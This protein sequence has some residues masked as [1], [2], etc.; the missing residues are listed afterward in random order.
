[1][2]AGISLYL[3]VQKN[4]GTIAQ[5]LWHT[6]ILDTYSIW[7]F[8]LLQNGNII[9]SYMEYFLYF[10]LCQS[11]S[12]L[13]NFFQP[14]ALSFSFG[15]LKCSAHTRS[16][17]HLLNHSQ[18]MHSLI[19]FFANIVVNVKNI[20]DNRYNYICIIDLW[21]NEIKSVLHVTMCIRN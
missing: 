7:I 15:N 16:E 14:R 18:I 20:I 11:K 2:I 5:L 6:T 8:I 9:Q 12:E 21:N 3:C 19:F 10:I 17:A 4:I 13:C 1:M